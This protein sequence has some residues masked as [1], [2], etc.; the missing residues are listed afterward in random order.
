MSATDIIG[1]SFEQPMH[2]SEQDLGTT[3]WTKV[4]YTGFDDGV[5]VGGHRE[6]EQIA[7]NER[8]KAEFVNREF[9][10]AISFFE[11]V[12]ASI[13][14]KFSLPVN[15]FYVRMEDLGSYSLMMIVDASR[16]VDDA[17]KAVYIYT[18][19]LFESP[20]CNGLDLSF[21]FLPYDGY[22]NEEAVYADDYL[23][24]YEKKA[25]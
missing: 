17:F 8:R 12:A 9:D 24:K 10:R 14:S 16:F 22:V 4:Y 20:D 1:E 7:M 13:E 6:R 3:K 19:E 2:S 11:Q 18:N 23:Y 15:S 21:S 5:V 25:S